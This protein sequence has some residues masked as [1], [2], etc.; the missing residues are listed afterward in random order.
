[1]KVALICRPF[2]F[3]GGIETATAGLMAELVRRGYEMDLLT[4]AGQPPVPG[5]TVRRLT[6]IRQ[7]SVLRLLSFSLA[8]ALAVRDR[9]YDIVQSH[10]RC[11][12]QDIYRAGEGTH[13][14]YLEA[15]GRRGAAMSP[16]HRVVLALERRIF[17]LKA[18][19]HI[20][21]N[22]WQAKGEIERLYG[23]PRS[24]VSLVY[25]GVDLARFHPDSR[26]RLRSEVRDR[27]GLPR[28]AWVVVFIGS[29]FERKGLGPLIEG[30]SRLRD[31]GV[32]LVVAG[33]G[34]AGPYQGL[35]SRLGVSDRVCWMG[36]R[37]DVECV[38]AAA[39]VVAV[40]SLYDPFPN[41]LL[42]GLASGVPGLASARTGG[43]E[44]IRSGDN[45]WVVEQ[46]TGAAVAGGLEALRSLDPLELGARSR[47]MAE[48]FTYAAQ[49]EAL[50]RIYRGLA[51]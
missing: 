18:A 26:V 42:E 40:P 24:Q 8:A 41:V 39:D 9:D 48:R 10:E 44:L 12:R 31:P 15:L 1:V 17:Q 43:A 19:R 36:P 22:S 33:K 29:G 34:H 46:C 5:V 16:Y 28:E 50:A 51:R 14:G 32:R 2:S 4:T 27:W 11:F 21:A 13:R 3:H 6:V 25:N 23:T 7:P 35:A 30:V 49:V 45:G 38:Y 47:A 37:R 20:V